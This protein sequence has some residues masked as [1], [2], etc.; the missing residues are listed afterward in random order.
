M[1]FKYL[2]CLQTYSRHLSSCEDNPLISLFRL[3]DLKDRAVL[4]LHEQPVTISNGSGG[5]TPATPKLYDN[6]PVVTPVTATQ[7]IPPSEPIQTPVT[8]SYSADLDDMNYFSEPEY[9]YSARNRT[10]HRTGLSSSVSHS[11]I[12]SGG[13]RYGTLDSYYK[14]ISDGPPPKP[15]RNFASPLGKP[16]SGARSPLPQGIQPRTTYSATSGKNKSFYEIHW[17]FIAHLIPFKPKMLMSMVSIRGSHSAILIH[18]DRLRIVRPA[19]L[20]PEVSRR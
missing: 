1:V 13:K 19:F 20:D 10:A 17:S 7:H 15:T 18:S 14:P 2:R 11:Y 6:S 3:R 12:P 5:N 4:K 9:D 8:L 16:I